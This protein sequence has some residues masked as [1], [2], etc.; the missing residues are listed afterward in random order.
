MIG[1]S[2]VAALLERTLQESFGTS[3]S[4]A[5]LMKLFETPKDSSHGEIAFPCF[6]LARS[7]RKAPVAIAAELAPKLLER[8]ADQG[9]ISAIQA[10]GPYVN[11]FLNKASLAAIL[12]PAIIN[13]SFLARRP[14]VGER[15]MVEFGN[16][17]TH[18]SFH[19]GHIRNAALGDS[20]ARLFD[21]CGFTTMRAAYLGD[22]GTH[23]A[24]CIWYLRRHKDLEVPSCNRLEFLGGA[25]SKASIELDV[26]TYSAVEIVGVRSARI[27]RI[28]PH[29]NEPLWLVITLLTAT[30]PATVV[31]QSCNAQRVKVGCLVPH[32]APGMHLGARQIGVVDRKG[33]NSDGLLLGEEELRI[34]TENQILNLQ[35]PSY[36][37]AKYPD[38]IGIDLVEIYHRSD[39]LL[40][41]QELLPILRDWTAEVSQILQ[42]LESNDPELKDF[43]VQSR[44][45]SLDELKQDFAWLN[46]SFDHYFFESEYGESSKE[47]V[48]KFQQAGVFIESEGAVGADLKKDGLGFCVLIK[49][50]GT[51]LY[52]T[53]DLVLAQRKFEEFSIDRSIYVV[54]VGQ[55]LH[56]QQ[57]FRCLELMG[58]E[59][60][61]SCYHCSYAQVTL[62]DGKMSSRKGNVILMSSLKERLVSK[63]NAEFLDKYK[64]EWSDEERSKAAWCIALGTMRYGMLNLDN[65]SQ[66]VF[67]MDAWTARTGNTGPYMMYAFARTR[68]ILRELGEQNFDLSSTRWDLLTHDTELE[69]L[70]FLNEYHATVNLA[71]ARYSPH[72]ICSYAYELA[73]LFSRMYQNC[74][75]LRAETP[76]LKQARAG[77]VEATG[78]VIKH[79]LSLIGI[80][81][82]ERM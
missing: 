81:S 7:L 73:K 16:V 74:S 57:V 13:G 19:V 71:C 56:F 9:E 76:E 42:R 51:A 29:P 79:A 17:N 10:N 72:I 23:V 27:E 36:L 64:G 82:V 14:D 52:A 66:V 22:E 1:Q 59:Q 45:W 68:S 61:Q 5:E 63:I 70:R 20:I 31:T 41:G 40:A 34:G 21:W 47:L 54:D 58:Y 25:Y 75:V 15:V 80:E 37:L 11:F 65:N 4:I 69:V 28:E 77:L 39:S 78:L 50:D 49:R 35:V 30:G 46:C 18:K 26:G 32:A 53:R 24:K 38:G 44:N 43:W 2:T 12:V 33:I 60:V 62:P 55:T 48:R 8:L 3:L 67:D 6:Q